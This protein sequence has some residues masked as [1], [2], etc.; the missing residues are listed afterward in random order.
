MEQVSFFRGPDNIKPTANS[1]KPFAPMCVA[2][3]MFPAR[4]N[5]KGPA[6]LPTHFCSVMIR[7]GNNSQLIQLPAGSINFNS[8][9]TFTLLLHQW[10]LCCCMVYDIDQGRPR[11]DPRAGRPGASTQ[12][13]S[14]NKLCKATLRSY[15]HDQ[16]TA[17]CFYIMFRTY[18]GEV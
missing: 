1:G 15:Q 9:P 8:E 4:L 18:R 14:S 3:P 17:G 7:G 16:D 5:Y 12:H 13:D 11:Q 10:Q 6:Y 2:C